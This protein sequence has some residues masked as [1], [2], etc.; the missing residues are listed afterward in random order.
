MT[1]RPPTLR[2]T[3]VDRSLRKRQTRLVLIVAKC[4]L[5]LHGASYVV[6]DS[7]LSPKTWPGIAMVVLA[8]IHAPR[9][10]H[11]YNISPI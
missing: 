2:P 9:M 3:N 10:L 4:L 5:F 8:A 11:I 1:C 6:N 7:G